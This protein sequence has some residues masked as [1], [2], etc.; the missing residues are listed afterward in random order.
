MTECEVL[1]EIN[2]LICR[3]FHKLQERNSI[4]F[5]SQRVTQSLWNMWWHGSRVAISSLTYSQQQ[6]AQHCSCSAEPKRVCVCVKD[7]TREHTTPNQIFKHVSIQS[8]T[9]QIIH[10]SHKG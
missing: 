2:H 3:L 4:T 8:R 10:F 9:H 5:L 6:M 7:S 1:A